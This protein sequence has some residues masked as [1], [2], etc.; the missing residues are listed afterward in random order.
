[1]EHH[2]CQPPRG[3][4]PIGDPPWKCPECH[5]LWEARALEPT[6]PAPRYTFLPEGGGYPGP[7]HAEW[8]RIGPK[9]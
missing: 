1:M 7:T 3:D 8:V 5:D 2:D 9:P 6:D 4:R